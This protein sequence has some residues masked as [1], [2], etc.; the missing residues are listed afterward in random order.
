MFDATAYLESLEVPTIKINNKEIKGVIL[1]FEEYLP[2]YEKMS[3]YTPEIMEKMKDE[4]KLTVG[5]EYQILKF[6]FFR[7][8]FPKKFRYLFTLDP[9]NYLM[10]SPR[11][12][13]DEAFGRFFSQVG[14][15]HGVWSPKKKKTSGTR[16][17]KSL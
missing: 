8:V 3:H 12:A 9:V 13:Q 11:A 15:A 14:I 1:S 6:K 16:S 7:A 17:Q 10:R 4:D 2:F 5:A